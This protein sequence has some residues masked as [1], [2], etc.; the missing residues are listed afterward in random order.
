M[1]LMETAAQ[2]RE[3]LAYQ[4][5]LLQHSLFDAS[6]FEVDS[7]ALN[8]ICDD[9]LVDISDLC[10]RHLDGCLCGVVCCVDDERRTLSCDC[11]RGRSNATTTA[12]RRD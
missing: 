4:S 5:Q 1:Q 12:R 7:R 9:L 3:R 6:L 2:Q 10:I 11:D 8:D